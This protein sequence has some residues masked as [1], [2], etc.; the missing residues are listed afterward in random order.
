MSRANSPSTRPTYGTTRVCRVWEGPRSTVYPRRV[1][2]SCP[3]TPAA[4]R[5]PKQAWTDAS[6]PFIG[7]GQRR[8]WARLRVAGV[9]TSKG[10]VL[11]LMREAE[12]LA[13]TR[14]GR[15]R[16]PRGA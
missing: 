8:A 15:R 4:K 5:R 6:S 1:R 2:A 11:R 14:V 16:V 7:G 9:R 10:R 13:P 12:L 3:A